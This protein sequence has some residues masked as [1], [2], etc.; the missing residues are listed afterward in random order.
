MTLWDCPMNLTASTDVDG[1][2]VMVIYGTRPEAIKVAPLIKALEDSPHFEPI[3]AVTGQHREMLDQVNDLFDIKPQYDLA[4]MVPGATLTELSVRALSATS[5]LIQQTTPDAV[6]VQGDTTTAFASALAAFYQ[7][8]PVI[9]LEAGLRTGNMSS[10]FPEEANRRLTAPLAALHLAPTSKSRQN[11][12]SEG[13]PDALIATTGNTVIDALHDTVAKPVT[14]KDPALQ[15]LVESGDRFVLVTAHRRESWGQPMRDA[16]TGLRRLAERFPNLHLVLPMHLNP[17]VRDVISDVL[18]DVPGVVIT[19]PLS[20]HEFCHTMRSAYIVLTDSGGVQE[21]APSLGKPVLVMRDT[22]ERP[23]AVDAG[24]VRLVGTAEVDVLEAMTLLLEDESAY[25]SMANAVNPYG[26]GH[27]A[28]RSVA[29]IGDLFGCGK[30][31][32]DF[33]P[34]TSHQQ[35]VAPNV[36]V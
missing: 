16:M 20:Y 18:G 9:H 13:I 12:L 7:Q 34:A 5:T 21:E 22:T 2:R 33:K 26:D 24:T 28:A 17:I 29:A 8:V 6:V 19:E 10:P 1:R 4:L 30:R 11:L 15:Q 23:E 25:A 27:A 36:W 35:R 14:F 32:P 31:L 3:V